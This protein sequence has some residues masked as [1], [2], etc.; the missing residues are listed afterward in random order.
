MMTIGQKLS[1]SSTMTTTTTM[2]MRAA[3][4]ATATTAATTGR[5]GLDPDETV[6]RK[7][8]IES[9]ILKS[10]SI[11]VFF[12][13]FVVV[14]GGINKDNNNDKSFLTA[15]EPDLIPAPKFRRNAERQISEN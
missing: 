15:I 9:R 2:K 6:E 8:P 13:V 10:V 12:L 1:S 11:F 5:H 4:T 7:P 14:L 3:T